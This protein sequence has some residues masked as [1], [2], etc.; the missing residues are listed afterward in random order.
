MIDIITIFVYVDDFCKGFFPYWQN[1]LLNHSK[2][3][4]RIR[5]GKLNLSEILT[6]LIAYHYSGF[7][8]F[9][10]YYKHLNFTSYFKD[11]PCYERFIS[12]IKKALKVL[13]YIIH[14]VSGQITSLQ[15]IDSTSLP[16]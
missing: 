5:S 6:I 1:Q 15:F 14:A 4:S 16:V 10:N 2:K 9:K 7:D 11:M 3:K 13:C 12:F 8:C